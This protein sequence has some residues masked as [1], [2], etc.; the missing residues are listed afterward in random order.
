VEEVTRVYGREQATER[1]TNLEV[2]GVPARHRNPFDPDFEGF[3]DALKEES[4]LLFIPSDHPRTSSIWKD[5]RSNDVTV[6]W[7]TVD[8]DPVDTDRPRLVILSDWVAD[9]GEDVPAARSTGVATG[10]FHLTADALETLGEVSRG[11]VGFAE[12]F[13]SYLD[14]P[15]NKLRPSFLRER[16]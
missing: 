16:E 2:H 7:L 8:T 6:N 4:S 1:D 5:L 3:D 12:A 9:L 15:A 14:D 13:G 10:I 11:D